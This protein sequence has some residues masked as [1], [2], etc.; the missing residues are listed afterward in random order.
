MSARALRFGLLATTIALAAGCGGDF[1]PGYRINNLRVLALGATIVGSDRGGS[2]AH[3]GE[4]VKLDVLWHDALDAD[5][6]GKKD[7]DGAPRP[8]AWGWTRCVNPEATTVFG[9]FAALGKEFAASAAAGQPPPE[10]TI[11]N[12][13]PAAEWEKT[14]TLQIPIPANALDGIATK[15][16]ASVGVIFFACPGDLVTDFTAINERR[17]E[18]PLKCFSPEGKELRSDEFT[19]GLRRIFVRAK[20]ENADPKI[21]PGSVTWGGQPWPAEE[22]KTIAPSCGPDE[23]G[24]DKCEG[25]AV[26][27]SMTFPEGTVESGVDEFG[28]PFTEQ[29]I[30]Q[31]YATEGLFEFPI[32]RLQDPKVRFAARSGRGREHTLWF[33]VRDNRGGVSWETRRILVE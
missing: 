12:G 20:D 6:D 17:N 27:I 5:R 26:E 8:R 10:F 14:S 13:V 19:I 3:P 28:V 9:C 7:A 2:Y 29:V 33:V 30:V 4:T 23:N 31:Y 11:L 24:F 18:L 21:A 1:D 25:N 16:A 22:V 32:K 15:S